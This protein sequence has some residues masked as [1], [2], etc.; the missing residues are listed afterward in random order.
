MKIIIPMAGAGS[1]F[2]KIGIDKCKHEILANSKTLFYWSMRSLVDFFDYEFIF[3]YRGDQKQEKF[4]TSE[5][6][7]LGIKKFKFVQ[8]NHITD[9]QA[10]TVLACDQFI[11]EDT[12]IGI[13]NIDTYVEPF[14]ILK[15]DIIANISGF[16]PSFKALGDRWSF[17]KL[18]ANHQYVT[19]VSEKKRISE[20]ATVGFYYFNKWSI[21]KE[22]HTSYR[23]DIIN[24]FKES[25]IAPMYNYLINDNKKV[26]FSIIPS[27]KIH[28]LGTPEDLYKFCPNYLEENQVINEE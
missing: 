20:Y 19:E 1:R 14:S 5:C 7:S 4:I 24:N 3:I 2:K 9:G 18:D 10:S 13:Y 21:F 22:L 28:V 12:P 16:I 23:T 27:E 6:K 26:S 15:K 25:Y 11:D 17:I 8:I